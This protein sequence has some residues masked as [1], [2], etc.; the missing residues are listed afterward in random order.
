MVVVSIACQW[1]P[2]PEWSI[3]FARQH[4]KAFDNGEGVLS[5]IPLATQLSISQ[6]QGLA[7]H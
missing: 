7:F 1:H 5:K 3:R 4:S 2:K 6:G